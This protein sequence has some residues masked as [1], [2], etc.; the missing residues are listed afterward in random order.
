M[1]QPWYTVKAM[2]SH[3]KFQLPNI[4]DSRQPNGYKSNNFHTSKQVYVV[5]GTWFNGTKIFLIEYKLAN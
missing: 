2:Y 3:P 5:A 4:T 1:F